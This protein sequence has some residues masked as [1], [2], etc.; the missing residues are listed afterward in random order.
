MS[1][2]SRPVEI[3]ERIWW[4][5]SLI[6]DDDF[7]CHAYLVEAG[8]QSALIDPGSSVTIESTLEKVAFRKR[9]RGAGLGGRRRRAGV[10]S[11]TTQ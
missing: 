3:A 5:G 10:D 11:V 9:P 1:E 7:Q 6:P 8:D 2:L 4:V